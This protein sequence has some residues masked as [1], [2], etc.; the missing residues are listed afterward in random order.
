MQLIIN[1]P[2]SSLSKKAGMFQLKLEQQQKRLAP[3]T[4]SRIIVSP[5]VR[6]SSDALLLALEHDIDLQFVDKFGYPKARVWSPAYGSIAN[7]RKA[8]ARFSEQ[9]EAVQW[10]ANNLKQRL[11]GCQQLLK[12]HQSMASI[13]QQQIQKCIENMAQYRQRFEEL[14]EHYLS[15]S[16]KASFRGWEGSAVRQYFVA[17]NLLLPEVYRFPKRSRRPAQDMFNTLLNY[18]Y[19]M[20]YSMVEAALIHAGLDPYMGV[21]HSNE[22]NRPVLAYDIIER[23]RFWAE[24]VAIDVCKANAIKAEMFQIEGGGYWLLAPGK[25]I[26]IEAM[27]TYLDDAGKEELSTEEDHS[28]SRRYKIQADA[29]AFAKYLLTIYEAV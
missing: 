26:V 3:S 28:K 9:P 8:Q 13:Q 29:H 12:T 14:P 22:Y 6:V 16:L 15:D 27:N 25:T 2:G 19:G 17:V 20:L 18:L 21:F 7:I 1:S 24:A 5:G 10:V 4:L 23:Y 11:N